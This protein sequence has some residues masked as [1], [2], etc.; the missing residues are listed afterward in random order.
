MAGHQ[1]KLEDEYQA[2]RC[3]AYDAVWRVPDQSGQYDCCLNPQVW[4]EYILAQL[5]PRS[6]R[7]LKVGSKH[8]WEQPQ[9][10]EITEWGNFRIL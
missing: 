1:R 3:R 5:H 8:L 10:A 6:V 4:V 9:G 7:C 2:V